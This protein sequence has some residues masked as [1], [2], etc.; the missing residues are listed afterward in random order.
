MNDNR[1]RPRRPPVASVEYAGCD[2]PSLGLMVAWGVLF[3]LLVVVLC[4]LI[5]AVTLRVGGYGWL[6]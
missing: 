3:A 2:E 1:R 5:V 6:L 4:G